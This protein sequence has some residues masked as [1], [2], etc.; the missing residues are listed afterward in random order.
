VTQAVCSDKVTTKFRFSR[1]E[2]TGKV[3]FVSGKTTHI[4]VIPA[5]KEKCN[6]AVSDQLQSLLTIFY[7]PVKREITV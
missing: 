3:H 5:Q 2:A 1:T 6:A 7:K 4:P